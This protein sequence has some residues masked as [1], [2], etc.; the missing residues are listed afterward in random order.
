VVADTAPAAHGTDNVWKE[1]RLDN[2]VTVMVPQFIA[3]GERI[4]VEVASDK[5]VERVRQDR[6]H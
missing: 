5:Y 6:H 1:A 3:P 2:G 4:R